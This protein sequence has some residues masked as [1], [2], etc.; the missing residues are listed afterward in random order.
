MSNHLIHRY[1]FESVT[2]QSQYDN[3]YKM[4]FNYD[5]LSGVRKPVINGEIYHDPASDRVNVYLMGKHYRLDTVKLYKSDTYGVSTKNTGGGIE[6]EYNDTGTFYEARQ[7]ELVH[8]DITNSTNELIIV[9]PIVY[10][11]Y[12]QN[13]QIALR[14]ASHLTAVNTDNDV[15][16]NEDLYNVDE[17]INYGRIDTPYLIKELIVHNHGYYMYD[18]SLKKII[19]FNPVQIQNYTNFSDVL[20]PYIDK[21]NTTQITITEYD[22]GVER[23]SLS[24]QLTATRY[25]DNASPSPTAT[26]SF[27]STIHRNPDFQY[28][29]DNKVVY[30]IELGDNFISYNNLKNKALIINPLNKYSYEKSAMFGSIGGTGEDGIY[31]DCS[32][33]GHS[34]EMIHTEIL[35]DDYIKINPYVKND[36]KTNQKINSE[37]DESTSTII[38]E[39]VFGLVAGIISI[40]SFNFVINKFLK[41]KKVA[42]E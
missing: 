30:Q 24:D 12:W 18:I 8:K 41:S 40:I 7:L 14:Y 39:T 25:D 16:E 21:P 19:F 1:L 22:V 15:N 20:D 9:V 11:K 35:K 13:D 26:Q 23:S 17:I 38:I 6:V 4:T 3:K 10:Y 29:P 28:I 27:E 36:K 5:D 32:P 2:V 33:V 31:F 34:D 37:K 42:T